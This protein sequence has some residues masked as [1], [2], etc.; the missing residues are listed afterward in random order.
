MKFF[1]VL[2]KVIYDLVVI[3]EMIKDLLIY[4][5]GI[6]EGFVL[7]LDWIVVLGSG[8][9]N[10][11]ENVKSFWMGVVMEDVVVNYFKVMEWFKV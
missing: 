9:V 10:M 5:I 6:L 3:E 4:Y 8:K 1:I 7:F 2:E 11:M